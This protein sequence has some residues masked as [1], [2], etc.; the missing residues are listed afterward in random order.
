MA[1]TVVGPNFTFQGRLTQNGQPANGT[2]AMD[3]RLFD[4]ATSPPGVQLGSV[5]SKSVMASNGLFTADL[6]SNGEFG[7]TA[8]SGEARWLEVTVNGTALT[9]RQP[10]T[11]TPYALFALEASPGSSLAA[12]DGNPVDAVVVDNDG[13]VGIGNSSPAELLHVGQDPD[14]STIQIGSY[15]ALGEAY[16]SASTIV[17]DNAKPADSPIDG[18][19]IMQSHPVYGARAIEMNF[20]RGI[21]FHARTGAT[22]AGT[23]FSN[24]VARITNS[25]NVGIGTTAPGPGAKLHVEGGEI[26]DGTLNIRNASDQT[27][28]FLS[29]F[30]GQLAMYAADGTTETV[31]ILGDEG[32][33]GAH[34]TLRGTDGSE[35]LIDADGG[36]AD[37]GAK[38]ALRNAAGVS[39]VFLDAK[40]G[41][42]NGRIKTQVLQITGGSDF[43]EQFDIGPAAT[44][45]REV[46]SQYSGAMGGNETATVD[47]IPGM[48]VCI[49]SQNPGKLIVSSAAYD[50][51][52]AGVISGAGGVKPGM[53]MGQAGSVADGAHPVALSGRVF[54]LCDASTGSIQPGDLLTTSGT[55]GHAMKVAD[56]AAAQGATIGK[57]MTSLAKGQNGL[58]LVLVNL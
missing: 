23:S 13:N 51:T 10:L 37:P 29:P 17:G 53:L 11:A 49:D 25:G 47:P 26:V 28:L 16:S 18:M 19:T 9:P 30:S 55:P 41:D 38:L 33:G 36:P 14:G 35:V 57:A 34:L 54:V 42:G 6:N 15:T 8:F 21:T 22:T 5:I 52:V 48:V 45:S 56:H 46:S 44:P 50:R 1:G 43:S 12:A 7:A 24:E 39:T 20:N 40:D 32:D 3:F 27:R 58:V 31:E 4:D 2:F